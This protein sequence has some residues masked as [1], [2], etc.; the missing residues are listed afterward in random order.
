VTQAFD[1]AELALSTLECRAERW[2]E[3]LEWARNY[4]IE[5]ELLTLR[6]QKN[7]RG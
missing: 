6:D 4:E 2:R 1:I 7:F 3:A 5:P